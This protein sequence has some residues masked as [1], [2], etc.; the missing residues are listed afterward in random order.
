VRRVYAWGY[1]Y[2]EVALPKIIGI[3]NDLV[4]KINKSRVDPNK[5]EVVQVSLGPHVIGAA[6]CHVDC[7]DPDT[8]AAGV[9]K[10]VGLDP[11]PADVNEVAGLKTFVRKW[12][13][14]NL[15][16]LDPNSD[17]SFEAWLVRCPYPEWRKK[18]L[19]AAYSEVIDIYRQ[20]EFYLVN[21]HGK[22]ETYPD[23]KHFRGINSRLDQFKA[24]IG[25]FFKLIEDVVYSHPSFIKHVPVSERPAYIVD[26]LYAV[27]ATY[28]MTD[29]TAFE[30]Q[31]VAEIMKACEFELYS[32]MTSFLPEGRGFMDL[33]D[34]VLAGSNH[35]RFRNVSV[36]VN[37][38]RMSGEMCTSLGNGFSN[39][40]FM[41]YT[42]ERV[43]ATN[44]VG[45]VEGDDG[46]FR[47]TGQPPTQSDFA[48][49]GLTI[50]AEVQHDLCKASFCGIIFDLE[51]QINVTDPR[52]VLVT[53][54]W[55]TRI[56]KDSRSSVL[57][58][59]LRC[60]ALSL[61][62]QYP[63]CPIIAALARY[64]LRVTRSCD[65]RKYSQSN[66]FNSWERE[67]LLEAMRDEKKLINRTPGMNTRFLVE[68]M[69]G[70]TVDEQ[71]RVEA[72]LDA[73]TDLSPIDL[74]S[75]HSN[76]L[77]AWKK[78]WDRYVLDIGAEPTNTA[79]MNDWR[80]PGF[81]N[82]WE[83]GGRSPD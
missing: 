73:K 28:Y 50:K 11:P 60:K 25:R 1:R 41:L 67:Q 9:Y 63:G 46:L 17:A 72:Y 38:T 30:S 65:V 37:A 52:E 5:R 2:G 24:A 56:Y 59:L 43:G 71:L 39:L 32:Y 27:G 36:D 13:R 20:V 82:E 74:E 29:Y 26:R 45:V 16:P 49:L 51:D 64:A 15:V 75:V 81:I 23:W 33:V 18:Q 40:M 42:C 22:D 14:E 47:M 70:V 21:S 57:K 19:S 62:H 8:V 53:F 44:V 12:V 6:A 34:T 66:A 58:S 80:I 4:V 68:D 31:F 83:S 61:A 3:K 48:K 10:R 69:Y 54:G 77:P 55:T 78:Y 76:M 35:C 7:D 79:F